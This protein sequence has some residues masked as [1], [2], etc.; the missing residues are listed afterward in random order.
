MAAGISI[1]KALLSAL[2]VLL[3]APVLAQSAL[4]DCAMQAASQYEAGYESVGRNMTEMD[5]AL[6]VEACERA[7]G[8]NPDNV[9]VKGWLARSYT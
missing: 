7:L 2:L 1:H 6:A 5:A 9:Q 4:D 3:P 8:E